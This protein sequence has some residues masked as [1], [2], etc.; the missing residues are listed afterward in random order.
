[1]LEP[2][3]PKTICVHYSFSSTAYTC[4][5][6]LRLSGT[7]R[8][9]FSHQWHCLSGTAHTYFSH[10]WHCPHVFLASTPQWHCPHM[11][12]ASVALPQWHCP[13]MC[14]ASTSRIYTS[15]AL[16]THVSR[17]SCSMPA[18]HGKAELLT[19]CVGQRE[20]CSHW[21]GAQTSKIHGCDQVV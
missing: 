19:H 2:F 17:I 14:L 15:V 8:T 18:G 21:T 4:I 7:A 5:S 13:H 12:L 10:Q 3:F 9:C 20:T 1:M 6:H 11:F 16:P